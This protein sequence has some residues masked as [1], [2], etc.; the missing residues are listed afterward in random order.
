MT[1]EGRSWFDDARFGMFVHWGIYSARGF[2]PSWPLVGGAVTFPYGQDVTVDDYFRDALG[3]APPP[4]APR[5]WMRA[6]KAAGMTYAVL[7][8]KHHDGFT[9]FPSE[10][11][12]FG[13]DQSAPGRDLVREF[14]DAARAE[15]LRVGLYYSLIDWHHPD[16]PAWTD[17]MRPYLGR[18]P[19]DDTAA[20]SRFAADM[21]AQL[22]HLLSSYGT[23]DQL[24]FDGGWERTA[25]EWGSTELEA[26][27][28][29][30]QP[31]I[32][33]NER[34]PG[35]GDYLSPEQALPAAPIEGWWETCLTM[36]HSWGPVEADHEWKSVRSLLTVL[37]EVAAGGGNLLLNISP[38]GD[39]ALLD[40]Q[41]ER[42]DGIADWMSR[43][44]ET[45]LEAGPAA[46]GIRFYGPVTQRENR[47]Y[48]FCV[49]R[50]QE[51]VVVRGMYGKRIEAVR[52]IGS[53]APLSFDLRLSA[54]DRI[55]GGDTVCD[56]LIDVP[57]SAIDPMITVLE[58]TTREE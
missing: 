8:T 20:W 44:G 55:V 47:T 40:W 10:H 4:D 5:E 12:P 18:T 42:L 26:M 49:M 51:Q 23:I 52:A 57:D 24:W 13:V 46:P 31:D 14:V 29:G 37:I 35:V 27:I 1:T 53:D 43:H 15:G 7:T 6:A 50:P 32:I 58:I 39:G 22:D 19:L 36:N 28:R 3:W 11:N 34:L 38:D 56:V 25:D 9:L 30:L 48:L 16:Y 41:R 2:E 33:I 45:V 17:E 21:T 54:L